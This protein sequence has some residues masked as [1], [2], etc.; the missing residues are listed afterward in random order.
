MATSQDLLRGAVDEIMPGVVADRRWL[1]QHPELGYQE[2]QTATFIEDRLR[3]LGVEDIRTGVGGTGITGIIRGGLGQGRVVGLRA[4]MDALPI[5]E[6]NEVE[7]VSLRP[8]TMHAC[9][10]DG[11]VSMLLGT[12]RML[13]ERRDQFA[14]SVKLFFQPA[15]EGGGG[16]LTMIQDGALDDLM[17]DAMFGI[18][19]WNTVPV[20]TIHA[21]V[22]PMMVGGDGFTI[23]IHGKGGHGAMPNLCV[24]PIVT[25]AAV[26]NA[27]QTV[28]SRT[29]NPL[30]PAVCTIGTI[31]AGEASN[32]I[33]DTVTMGGT[34][35]FY[36]QAQR[37]TMR[38]RL[39]EIVETTAAAYGARAEVDLEWGVPST[40]NDPEMTAIVRECA[41][42]VVG[43]EHVSDGD[44]LMVSEDMSEF[45]T[46]VPGCYFLVGTMNEA[47]GLN[48]GH[49]T[50]RFDIDEDALAIGIETM[51][52]TV[53]TYLDRNR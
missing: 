40:D 16:A 8:G 49:H 22:G 51:T 45:L 7:Y 4:D 34:I 48:W 1:H 19:L 11:H 53:L 12:A 3:S 26:I 23:T 24:D 38:K 21:R 37:M 30:L 44:L 43:A 27:L 28:V 36:D 33:P 29:N 20:G 14:G 17:P 5:L 41:A 35:R 32:V 31:H 47:R 13:I 2:F 25:A 46:R 52:R 18:H 42:G 6:E 9:G 39:T 15:E 10:H 50:S